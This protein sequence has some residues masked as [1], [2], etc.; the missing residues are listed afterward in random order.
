MNKHMKELLCQGFEAP[1]P[2]GKEAF[3]R[4][5][6]FLP[7]SFP[8]FLR[9][10]AVYIRKQVWALSAV[11]FLIALWGACIL[12]KD[13]L[14]T[15]SA[16]MPLLALTLLTESGRSERYGMAELEQASR[17]SLKSVMLARFGILGLENLVLV[18]LC[19]PFV[20]KTSGLSL[21]QTGLYLTCPYLLT[22]F[23]GAGV[24]RRVRDRGA[25]Y[26]CVGIALSVSL[27][28]HLLRQ[29]SPVFYESGSL[30]W[31]LL[32]EIFFGVGAVYQYY[33]MIKACKW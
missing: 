27:G 15:M 23:F 28:N 25:D 9:T 32:A 6:R 10:Q 5:V 21:I 7:V 22:S 29:N 26:M 31:W 17:F 8:A 1:P 12:K 13:V 3:L 2:A 20:F 11:L 30:L 33:Q 18:C 16:F 24:L 4:R 14:W 19:L